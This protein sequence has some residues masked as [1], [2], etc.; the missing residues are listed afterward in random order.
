VSQLSAAADRS[1]WAVDS[2]ICALAAAPI[3]LGGGY[4]TSISELAHVIRDVV[5]FEGE[6]RFD[7]SK[8][9]G[10]PL[11]TLD[12][13]E[14]RA[15]GWRAAVSF[16]DALERTCHWFLQHEAQLVNGLK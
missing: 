8:P 13:S 15:L 1:P 10:M 7:T 12:A 11:K 5:G 6:I 2:G 4:E 3:N 14:L 9:D 16:H